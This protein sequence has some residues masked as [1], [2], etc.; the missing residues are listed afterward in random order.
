LGAVCITDFEG[1]G[2]CDAATEPRKLRGFS[3][4]ESARE[5]AMLP[6]RKEPKAKKSIAEALVRDM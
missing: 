5:V 3:A 4:R 6:K 2:G 1:A